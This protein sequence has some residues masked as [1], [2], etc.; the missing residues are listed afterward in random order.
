M[1]RC[2]NVLRLFSIQRR[3]EDPAE[4]ARVGAEI[5]AHAATCDD[6]REAWQTLTTPVSEDALREWAAISAN[7][8]PSPTD[9]A[10]LTRVEQSVRIFVGDT[11]LFSPKNQILGSELLALAVLP[12]TADLIRIVEDGSQ[13]LIT[14]SD[15]IG[16]EPDT[17]FRKAPRF[18]R[19]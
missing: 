7:R 13:I 17:R 9:V 12:P 1:E 5:E 4:R 14:P 15:V 19:G 2:F 6:C 10:T 18:L 16:L 11:S 3:L 8:S